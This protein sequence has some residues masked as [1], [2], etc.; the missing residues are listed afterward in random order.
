M[1]MVSLARQAY[2]PQHRCPCGI[3]VREVGGRW[4]DGAGVVHCPGGAAHVGVQVARS[5]LLDPMP[6]I[7]RGCDAE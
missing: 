7:L 2:P 5:A 3:V 4:T 1:D 6:A